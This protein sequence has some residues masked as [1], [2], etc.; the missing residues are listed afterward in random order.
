MHFLKM[1]E[2]VPPHLFRQNVLLVDLVGP[3][4]DQVDRV[5]HRVVVA[6]DEHLREAVDQMAEK[7][8][9]LEVP[10]CANIDHGHVRLVCDS[11]C[12]VTCGMEAMCYLL[13]MVNT[14]HTVDEP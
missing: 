13:T 1:L 4:G 7:A 3:L 12:G 9:A 11:A 2:P 14:G 5:V 6:L 10:T 8:D